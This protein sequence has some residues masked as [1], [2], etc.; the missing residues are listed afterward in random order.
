MATKVVRIYNKKEL[1]AIYAVERTEDF[2]RTEI[3][4][5][6][7]RKRSLTPGAVI[8]AQKL[9]SDEVIEFIAKYPLPLGY[10][11]GEELQ[12]RVDEFKKSK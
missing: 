3:N 11:L 8:C 6:I 7:T 1:Q 12:Q 9:S 10:V 5:I 2:V 4:R